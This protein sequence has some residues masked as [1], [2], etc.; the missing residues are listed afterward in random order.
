MAKFW[1]LVAV[2]VSGS[3]YF[4]ATV[5]GHWLGAIFT[6]PSMA[7]L[8]GIGAATTLILKRRPR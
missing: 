1:I 2:L 8:L 6:V 4:L 5:H 7:V 3:M